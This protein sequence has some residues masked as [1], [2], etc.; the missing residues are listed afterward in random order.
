MCVAGISPGPRRFIVVMR[1]SAS[2]CRMCPWN[3]HAEAEQAE[4]ARDRI[5]ECGDPAPQVEVF[6]EIGRG[7]AEAGLGE[8]LG[9][10]RA[11]RARRADE[12]ADAYQTG[13]QGQHTEQSVA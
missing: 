1:P 9:L 3:L 6:L 11:R 8:A 12:D 2:R 4:L 7:D 5:A 13:S 10:P